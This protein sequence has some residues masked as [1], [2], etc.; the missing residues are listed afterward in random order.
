MIGVASYGYAEGSRMRVC[1]GCGVH[2]SAAPHAVR[3]QGCASRLMVQA[4]VIVRADMVRS[5]LASG[6]TL[7][8]IADEVGMSQPGLSV[9]C[10]REKIEVR[11]G[12]RS[13]IENYLEVSAAELEHLRDEGKTPAQIAEIYGVTKNQVLQKTKLL[14]IGFKRGRRIKGGGNLNVTAQELEAA[15][16]QGFTLTQL[17]DRY[18]C[19][20]PYMSQVALRLG[21]VFLRGRPKSKTPIELAALRR[22]EGYPP[23]RGYT[24]GKGRRPDAAV[25]ALPADA[26]LEKLYWSH[27]AKEIAVL[28]GVPVSTAMSAIRY[29]LKGR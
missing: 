16:D 18:G 27:S 1:V 10:K 3:C 25:N 19:S 13:S 23:A 20:G 9:F 29:A 5:R 21:V 4:R 28:Y 2:F 14:G 26:E 11:R 22:P 15:R 12:R 8:E 17:A 6:A 24:Q 7:K